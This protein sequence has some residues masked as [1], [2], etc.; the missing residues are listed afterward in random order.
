MDMGRRTDYTVHML[1]TDKLYLKTSLREL[2]RF[3]L[4]GH[5]VEVLS[6][7]CCCENVFDIIVQGAEVVRSGALFNKICQLFIYYN[8]HCYRPTAN[9]SSRT[10]YE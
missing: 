2:S 6:P 8:K 9:Q 10:G 7:A 5:L 4:E 3:V 1:A